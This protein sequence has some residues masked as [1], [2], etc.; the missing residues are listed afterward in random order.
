VRRWPSFHLG[1]WACDVEVL[2]R[3]AHHVVAQLCAGRPRRSLNIA[4]LT[5]SA[6][7]GSD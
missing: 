5:E 7:K 4:E 1:P 6:S 3:H 2:A